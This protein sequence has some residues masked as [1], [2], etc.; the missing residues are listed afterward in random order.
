MHWVGKRPLLPLDSP[1]VHC[2]SCEI[3]VIMS[4]SETDS[5]SSPFPS[6][7][8]VTI[9]ESLFLIPPCF[10]VASDA[11]LFCTGALSGFGGGCLKYPCRPFTGDID[12]G[13]PD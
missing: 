13:L 3:I 7:P 12:L 11:E 8:E 4:P 1:S 10:P 9:P 5:S 2:E 6:N